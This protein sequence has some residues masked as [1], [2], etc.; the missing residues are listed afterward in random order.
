M[1]LT[2][3]QISIIL[4]FILSTKDDTDA[5]MEQV[6]YFNTLLNEELQLQNMP[7]DGTLGEHRERLKNQLAQEQRILLMQKAI[8]R[9]EQG[10]EAA[11]MLIHKAI[12]CIMHLE[13]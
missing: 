6:F 12:P 5:D 7:L 4:R 2:K 1:Q 3:K 11:L 8:E 10:K 13:N 9:S